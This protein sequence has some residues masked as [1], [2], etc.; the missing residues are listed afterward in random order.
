MNSKLLIFDLDDT[1]LLTSGVIKED[2]SNL[3]EI[4]LFPGV[5]EFLTTN[6]TKK[7][8]VTKG[9]KEIQEKKVN[10]LGIKDDFEKIFFPLTDA[11][12]ITC[13]KKIIKQYPNNESWVIGNKITS[14]IKFGNEL[15]LKTVLLKK[16]KYKTLKAKDDSEVPDYEIEEFTEL[17]EVL[18]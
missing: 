4:Q 6:N 5:K 7:F 13:F 3:E 17:N 8:L 1:L 10:L 16:G 18:K 14:E 11:H 9:D 12:K 2:Y 15:G